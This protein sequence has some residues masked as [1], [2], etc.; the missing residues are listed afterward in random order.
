M[1][2]EIDNV[3]GSVLDVR[4]SFLKLRQTAAPVLNKALKAAVNVI[5]A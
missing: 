4:Q 3:L 2:D 5:T 1:T